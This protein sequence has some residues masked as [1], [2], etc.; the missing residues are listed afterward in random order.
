MYASKT[1][2]LSASAGRQHIRV[3]DTHRRIYSVSPPKARV[4][5]F[6]SPKLHQ[7]NP[8]R[9]ILS[10]SVSSKG[11]LNSKR[12]SLL[13]SGVPASPDFPINGVRRSAAWFILLLLVALMF[14]SVNY[15]KGVCIYSMPLCILWMYV[16]VCVCKYI[17]RL[18]ATATS[19]YSSPYYTYIQTLSL[20]KWRLL[21]LFLPLLTSL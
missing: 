12:S 16:C 4:I 1:G 15:K 11:F 13:F 14:I 18:G 20:I 19:L 9:L 6:H 8:K 7:N 5:F 2:T 21:L 17:R 3:R 10:H